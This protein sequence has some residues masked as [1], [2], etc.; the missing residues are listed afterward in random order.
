MASRLALLLTKRTLK[1][2]GMFINLDAEYGHQ[3]VERVRAGIEPKHPAQTKEQL[4]THDSFVIELPQ[5]YEPRPLRDFGVLWSI[6]FESVAR[7]TIHMYQHPGRPLIFALLGKVFYTTGE[8][9]I[10]VT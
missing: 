10:F 9:G 8:I 3:I 2:G 5:S 7:I 6:G 4:R 1:P